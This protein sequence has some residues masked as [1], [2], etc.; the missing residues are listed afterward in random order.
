MFTFFDI[1]P[2]ESSEVSEDFS[3]DGLIEFTTFKNRTCEKCG[4]GY[5]GRVERCNNCL[6]LNLSTVAA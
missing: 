1:A 5:F 3:S 2:A 6:E 4:T